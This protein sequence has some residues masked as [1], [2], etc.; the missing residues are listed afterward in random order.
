MNLQDYGEK[1]FFLGQPMG[2][3]DDTLQYFVFK[4]E[5][6]SAKRARSDCKGW[7]TKEALV[8]SISRTR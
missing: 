4:R 2:Y 3:Q 1:M 8:R 6:F 5:D 7:E